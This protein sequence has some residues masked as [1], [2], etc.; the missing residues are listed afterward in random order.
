MILSAALTGNVIKFKEAIS[1]GENI[2]SKDENGQ[3]VL[4]IVS[5]LRPDLVKILISNNVDVNLAD[6]NK[7]TPLHWAVEFD[8]YEIVQMLLSNGANVNAVD[9]LNE[10]PLHWAAWT[11]HIKSAKVLLEYNSNVL[12]KNNGGVTPLDLAI[13]QEHYELVNLFNKTIE[14]LGKN[15]SPNIG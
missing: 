9:L 7:I 2:H 11:G 15:T 5:K 8:N 12:F 6:D 13:K 3:S 4:S 14:C 1:S 10:T